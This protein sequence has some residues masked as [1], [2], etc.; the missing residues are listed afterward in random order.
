MPLNYVFLFP[1]TSIVATIKIDI[2]LRGKCV[3]L[4][5]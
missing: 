3:L 1:E 2:A 4:E 5:R